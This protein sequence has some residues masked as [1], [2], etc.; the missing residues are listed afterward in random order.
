MGFTDNPGRDSSVPRYHEN[1]EGDFYVEN[2]VCTSCGA[3]EAEAPG[4]IAHSTT[5]FG[6]CYFK[7]QPQTPGEVAQ[8]INAVAVSCVSGL[9][10]AG[11]DKQVL[12]ELHQIGAAAD[13]DQEFNHKHKVVT[14][15]KVSFSFSGTLSEVCKLVTAAALSEYPHQDNKILG[16]T[17]N[18]IDSFEFIHRW[19]DGYTGTI[20]KCYFPSPRH[21]TVRIDKE[22]EGYA[23]LIRYRAIH[24]NKI[25]GQDDRISNILWR[26]TENNRFHKDQIR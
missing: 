13:C 15:D 10:Y 16:L 18:A 22:K 14:W 4:L 3:P 23:S 9:R 17:T 21:I 24:L 20:Y 25:L 12:K 19:T 7:R 26:D 6:H 2:N 5:H 8:A 11:N 1:A